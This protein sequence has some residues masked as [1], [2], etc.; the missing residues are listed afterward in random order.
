MAGSVKVLGE[1]GRV[2]ERNVHESDAWDIAR[3]V[4]DNTGEDVTLVWIED[5]K[6]EDTVIFGANSEE[7]RKQAVADAKAQAKA[8][9]QA[10]KDAEAREKLPDVSGQSEASKLEAERVEAAQAEGGGQITSTQDGPD[11]SPRP[12]EQT[13]KQKAA[14][15]RRRKAAADKKK[16][17]EAAASKPES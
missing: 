6:R 7:A 5:P 16:A 11:A 9:E 17:D 1:D 12:K 2:I 14:A 8:D 15:A 3:R 13:A 4:Q 10:V